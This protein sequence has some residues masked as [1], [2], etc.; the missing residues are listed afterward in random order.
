MVEK[1]NNILVY[2][3]AGRSARSGFTLVEVLTALAI[4]AVLGGLLAF[5]FVNGLQY[6]NKG[7]TRTDVQLA[8]RTA[9]DTLARS[10]ATAHEVYINPADPTLCVYVPAKPNTFP[11]Q[12]DTKIVRFWQ[13]LERRHQNT[14][15]YAPTETNA[16]LDASLLRPTT[17]FCW[18]D[19]MQKAQEPAYANLG[20]RSPELDRDSRFLART[21]IDT[22]LASP[23]A[24]SISD[25]AA[26]D[27]SLPA[28]T[29]NSINNNQL[30]RAL[31]PNSASFDVPWLRFTM[32]RPATSATPA[33]LQISLTVS[34]RDN[35]GQ[36]QDVHLER[37][38]ELTNVVH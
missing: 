36:P 20:H 7:R 11:P 25:P 21:E 1:L 26:L 13:V 27:R 33:L 31:T 32:L 28:V 24:T 16:N 29:S 10:L 22:T 34:K 23:I 35:S 2:K 37:A 6:L 5:P 38:V 15:D 3:F 4:M 9:M 12:P 8:A 19:N 30:F 18:Y 14:T 17:K